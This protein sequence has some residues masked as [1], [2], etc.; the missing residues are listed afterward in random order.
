MD[1]HPSLVD[2]NKSVLVDLGVANYFTENITEA[3]YLVKQNESINNF[4]NKYMYKFDGKSLQRFE[5]FL[6]ER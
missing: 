5:S 4:I 1:N 6:L 3:S 2:K